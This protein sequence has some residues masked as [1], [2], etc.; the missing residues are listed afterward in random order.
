M[1]KPNKPK[2][3]NHCDDSLYLGRFSRTHH[4]FAISSIILLVILRINTLHKDTRMASIS[5]LHTAAP[6]TDVE[7][8]SLPVSKSFISQVLTHLRLWRPRFKQKDR[9]QVPSPQT[10]ED[11]VSDTIEAMRPDLDEYLATPT[12]LTSPSFSARSS[13]R[14][15]VVNRDWVLDL[16]DDSRRITNTKTSELLSFM[17]S[18]APGLQ[19]LPQLTMVDTDGVLPASSSP[20]VC[21]LQTELEVCY[22]K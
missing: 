21:V 19:G 10:T 8:G 18:N 6:S 9:Q 3:S 5:E 15:G 22:L 1:D 20:E 16:G 7:I 4:E 12:A 17:S 13:T 11:R 14:S 2:S